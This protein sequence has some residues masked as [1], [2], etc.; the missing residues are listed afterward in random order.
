MESA[1]AK[2]AAAIEV[3]FERLRTERRDAMKKIKAID[4]EIVAIRKWV[5]KT[6]ASIERP[7]SKMSAEGRANI[8]KGIRARWARL[9]K[10]GKV[11]KKSS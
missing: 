11:A 10:E 9:R 1:R 4:D 7:T 3:E 8:T 6:T 2:I 5:V